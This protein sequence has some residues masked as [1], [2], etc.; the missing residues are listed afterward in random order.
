MLNWYL[1]IDRQNKDVS[2]SNVIILKQFEEWLRLIQGQMSRLSDQFNRV[3]VQPR[4]LS[5]E[6]LEEPKRTI[7]NLEG[8]ISGL[9]GLVRN[10]GAL[11]AEQNRD[12]S[13][14]RVPV[15]RE[16]EE[17]LRLVQ[18]QI[19]DVSSTVTRALTGGL[20][21]KGT[22]AEEMNKNVNGEPPMSTIPFLKEFEEYLELFQKQ[23][24]RL[25]GTVQRVIQGGNGNQI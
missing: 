24:N 13:V 3:L 25:G 17:M 8:A 21:L 19:T 15:L 23:I 10:A 14:S 5:V 22:T 20:D 2:A 9:N 6:D 4:T 16:M 7:N 11:Q 18:K 1:I 12:F